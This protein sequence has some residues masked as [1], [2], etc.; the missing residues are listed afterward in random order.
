M[1][2][3]MNEQLDQR[4]VHSE[5]QQIKKKTDEVI[6]NNKKQLIEKITRL[7]KNQDKINLE[8]ANT[9]KKTVDEL[10]QL[11]KECATKMDVKD[12]QRL[13]RQFQRFAE[14]EDLRDLYKRCIPEIAKFE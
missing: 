9:N 7:D 5:I 11:S 2:K 13:W 8:Q 10:G 4:P 14:Y 6:S 12:A 1:Q 3:E